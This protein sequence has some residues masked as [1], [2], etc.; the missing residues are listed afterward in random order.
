MWLE[1]E[2]QCWPAITNRNAIG[3]GTKSSKQAQQA[4][5]GHRPAGFDFIDQILRGIACSVTIRVEFGMIS[6]MLLTGH[7]KKITRLLALIGLLL[8]NVD[9]GQV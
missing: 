5:A 2:G 3:L 8:R 6:T 1:G 7:L 9:I 4:I